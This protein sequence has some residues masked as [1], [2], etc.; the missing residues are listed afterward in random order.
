[1]LTIFLIVV[2]MMRATAFFNDFTSFDLAYVMPIAFAS[3]MIALL[4]HVQMAYVAT[5]VFSILASALFHSGKSL[6]FDMRYGLFVFIVSIVAIYTADKITQRSAIVKTGLFSGIAGSIILLSY[7]LLEGS[8]VKAWWFVEPI[9][10]AFI[11]ALLTIVLVLGLM[12][13]F[14]TVFKVLSN[15]KLIELGNHNHP[16]LQRLMKEAPGTYHHSLMVANLA[17][18][19]AEKLGANSLLCRVSAYYHDVGKLTRP[20]FFIENHTGFTNPHDSLDPYVSR[21]MLISHVS[22][23]VEML[24]KHKMPKVIVDIVAQHHGTTVIRYFYNKALQLAVEEQNSNLHVDEFR[25]P[26]PRP[27][28][29]EALIILIADSVEAAVRSLKLANQ[30]EISQMIDRIIKEKLDD[31]QFNDCQVTLKDL[32]I[33]GSVMKQLLIGTRHE[34]ISY[35]PETKVKVEALQNQLG[36]AETDTTQLGK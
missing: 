9:A 15:L 19:A 16:L 1:V 21:A 25:Y 7:K 5:F 31:K 4:H 14:E 35:Q 30:D 28:T 27:Q 10:Y 6:L 36:S 2:I 11:H 33:I 18:A 13:I 12:P 24:K 32:E 8:E 20:S 3:V 26:G 23:G 29:I 17:G 34:R 22:D